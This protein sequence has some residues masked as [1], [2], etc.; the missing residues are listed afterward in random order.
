[1]G[2]EDALS[3]N[4]EEA[5]A[6]RLSVSGTLSVPDKEQ[7]ELAEAI[8]ARLNPADSHELRQMSTRFGLVSGMLM[9]IV[10]LFW[11]LAIHVA[12][13]EWGGNSGPSSILFDLNFS[14]ISWLVP[15]LVF[16]ATLLVSLSQESAEEQLPQLSVA[17]SSFS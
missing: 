14:Q 3:S 6:S 9:M 12:G 17:D 13:N 4:G 2:P 15:V 11:F 7:L 8:L 10:L 5:E 16:L 1:M